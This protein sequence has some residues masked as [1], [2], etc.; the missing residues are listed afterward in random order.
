MRVSP[1]PSG[2]V[3]CLK[4]RACRC[5]PAAAAAALYGRCP[6][7]LPLLFSFVSLVLPR[8]PRPHVK[9]YRCVEPFRVLLRFVSFRGRRL[10]LVFSLCLLQQPV[11]PSCPSFSPVPTPP[12][13]N[14]V[15]IPRALSLSI[16]SV[17]EETQLGDPLL[18]P[19]GFPHLHHRCFCSPAR[20]LA[21]CRSPL[22]PSSTVVFGFFFPFPSF[23]CLFPSGASLMLCVRSLVRFICFAFFTI[24]VPPSPLPSARRRPRPSPLAP[25]ED[26][27]RS[28]RPYICCFSPQLLLR[29]RRNRLSSSRPL[30]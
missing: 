11:C 22:F 23:V 1:P 12:R 4:S 29:L 3:W 6:P 24:L 25:A 16:C 8:P 26:D 19:V 18:P 28:R 21:L 20:P 10:R 13:L 14:P 15:S 5:H 27:G 2:C 30:T 9:R 17:D 7:P